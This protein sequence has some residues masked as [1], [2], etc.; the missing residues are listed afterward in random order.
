MDTVTKGKATHSIF[1]KIRLFG[2]VSIHA[3]NGDEV[4]QAE[5][6]VAEKILRKVSTSTDT[7]YYKNESGEKAHE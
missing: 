7:V 2:S 1:E 3:L 5:N 4:F 6:L